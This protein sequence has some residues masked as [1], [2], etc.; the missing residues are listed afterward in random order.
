MVAYILKHEGSSI[1]DF[2]QSIVAMLR[3]VA[4]SHATLSPLARAP[5]D[6]SGCQNPD[7]DGVNVM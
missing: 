5:C 1:M 6:S 2:K 3:V 7:A 4:V